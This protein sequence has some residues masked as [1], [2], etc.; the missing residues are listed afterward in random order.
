MQNVT[1]TGTKRHSYADFPRSLGCGKRNY[2]INA[3]DRENQADR[4]KRGGERG[5]ESERKKS[6]RALQQLLHCLDVHDRET[7]SYASDFVF[8][9]SGH[10]FRCQASANVQ[11]AFRHKVLRERNVKER[12][13]IF[14]N[15]LIFSIVRDADDLRELAGCAIHAETFSDGVF[16]RPEAIGHGLVDDRDM[17][18]RCVVGI[19]EVAAAEKGNAHRVEVRGVNGV[20]KHTRQLFSQSCRVALDCDRSFTRETAHW[21][22]RRETRGLHSGQ[23]PHSAFDLAIKGGRS[24]LVVPELMRVHRDVQNMIWIEAE[25]E[26]LNFLQ[27]ANE[28][29]GGDKQHQRTRNLRDDH[30]IAQASTMNVR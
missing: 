23:F 2:S 29:S 6:E 15:R 18:R 11:G 20:V 8:E 28:K 17:R 13:R 14:A 5:R 12:L 27:A 24:R 26:A 10:G 16:V 22:V 19:R 9:R 1:R 7:R 25:I 4:A 3:D 21:Y 30:K